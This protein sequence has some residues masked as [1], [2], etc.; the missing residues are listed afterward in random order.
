VGERRTF[1]TPIRCKWNAPIHNL[2]KAI[3]NH[4]ELFLLH[5]E[6]WHAEKAAELRAYVHELK[7]WIHEKEANTMEN[8]GE[9]S[10]AQGGDE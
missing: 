10:R 9:S 7:T 4:T 8:L 6:P 3:D 5:G 2:L 1:D